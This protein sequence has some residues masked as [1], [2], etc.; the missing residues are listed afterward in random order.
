MDF[1]EE[2]QIMREWQQMEDDSH[3]AIIQNFTSFNPIEEEPEILQ[4][5]LKITEFDLTELRSD[6]V[7]F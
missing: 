6:A 4:P 5:K 2:E 3:D 7:N 1:D